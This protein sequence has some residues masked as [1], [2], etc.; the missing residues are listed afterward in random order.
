MGVIKVKAKETAVQ[1]AAKQQATAVQ[2]ATAV[3]Q[4]QYAPGVVKEY[5]EY[6]DAHSRHYKLNNGTAKSVY[7]NAPA[8]YYDAAEGSWKAIDN[9]LRETTD[10]Y[11]TAGG[12][13]KTELSKPEKGKKVR[14]TTDGIA[15]SWEYLG[16]QN[17]QAGATAMAL[18][19]RQAEETVLRIGDAQEGDLKNTDG[20]AVY[21]EADKDTDIEYIVQGARGRGIRRGIR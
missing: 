15:V 7:S 16:R 10:G 18:S 3:Q 6:T 1:S 2:A 5:K 13:Y 17:T 9:S 4:E 19:E 20:L 12:K 14:L 8:N 11:E 21:E